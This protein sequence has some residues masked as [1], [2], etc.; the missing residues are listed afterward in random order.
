MDPLSPTKCDSG[1]GPSPAETS[2]QSPHQQNPVVEPSSQQQEGGGFIGKN[3]ITDSLST[4]S[5]SAEPFKFTSDR[6]AATQLSVEAKE[7]V[8]KSVIATSYTESFSPYVEAEYHEQIDVTADCERSDPLLDYAFQVLYEITYSPG[9][10][11][12]LCDQLVSNLNSWP[13]LDES[14]LQILVDEIISL[15]IREPNFRYNGA[16]LCDAITRGLRAS[17]NSIDFRKILLNSCR[18]IHAERKSLMQSDAEYLRGFALFMSELFVHMHREDGSGRFDLLAGAVRELLLTLLEHPTPGN[19]KCLCQILKLSGS[20]IEDHDRQ[21]HER[22]TPEMDQLMTEIER[23]ARTV[24]MQMHMKDLLLNMI[25]LRVTDWG[26]APTSPVVRESHA[27]SSQPSNPQMGVY[28]GPDGQALTAEE[29]E[30]LDQGIN[31]HEDEEEYE[32]AYEEDTGM[33]DEMAEAFEKF[34]MMQDALK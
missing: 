3:L 23:V 11:T 21:T 16:R 8:P 10:F 9:H 24:E 20:Y 28:Y 12:N 6:P 32:Y 7:F 17:G 19:V 26:R 25:E 30:F 15:A 13:A 31:R 34:L 5:I 22:K 2:D 29:T 4:L 14:V 33:D 1:T 18:V 27:V